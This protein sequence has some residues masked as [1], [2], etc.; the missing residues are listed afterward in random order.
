[1]MFVHSPCLKS[2]QPGFSD[3][4]FEACESAF[5]SVNDYD[6]ASTS[7]WN[8]HIINTVLHTLIAETAPSGQQPLYKF[9]VNSTI[10]QHGLDTRS[11]ASEDEGRPAGKKGMHSA[12]GAF[13]N[14]EKDG[15]WNF[16]YG[17][18][19]SKGFDVIINV[20]WISLS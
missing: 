15:M 4:K 18:S 8:T 11:A 16:K 10:I 7:S 1:M 12:S 5:S 6:H 17:K 9:A 13:W 20:I 3:A 2:S 14:S 19:E